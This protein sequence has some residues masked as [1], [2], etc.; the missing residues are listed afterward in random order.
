MKG[1]KLIT[2]IVAL[3]LTAFMIVSSSNF[4]Y[5]VFGFL[6]KKNVKVVEAA[7]SDTMKDTMD[8]KLYSVIKILYN[9]Q[10][11]WLKMVQIF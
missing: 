7:D 4:N 6:G 1:K 10:R 5:P 11:H 3:V 2:R 9:Y 8:P